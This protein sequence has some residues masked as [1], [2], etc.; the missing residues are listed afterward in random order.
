M[1]NRVSPVKNA[2]VYNIF[3][4]SLD[5]DELDQLSEKSLFFSNER[6]NLF[7]FYKKDHLDLG[8]STL[9]ENILEYLKEF[10]L[11]EVVEKIVLI[12]NIRIL[13]YTFNPVCF[14][15][16]YDKDKNLVCAIAEVHNTFGEMK[17]FLFTNT[18]RNQDGF[19]HKRYTKFFYVSPFQDL[20]TDFEFKMYPP[21]ENLRIEIDDWQENKKVFLS[22]YKGIKKEFSTYQLL[23]HFFRFPL[24][25]IHII[26]MIHFQAL[27]LYLKKVP[28]FKKMQNQELQK[29][30]YVGKDS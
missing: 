14:Y 19:F 22:T 6:W 27:K 9:K 7:S 13:G 18:D 8:K 17:P 15:Y 5:L 10:T 28:Y 29:G 1:H 16:C 4:F 24:V 3:T 25:T 26:V 30:V 20:E 12:S 23:F 21:N 11:N 2:F